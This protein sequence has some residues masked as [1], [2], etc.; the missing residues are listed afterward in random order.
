VSYACAVL[1]YGGGAGDV[2]V[3]NDKNFE[4]VTQR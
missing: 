3:L 2:L 1:E 4:E